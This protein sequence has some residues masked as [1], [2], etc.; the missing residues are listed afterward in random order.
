MRINL[1]LRLI[2]LVFIGSIWT[3][4]NSI[5]ILSID[6]EGNKRLTAEDIMRNAQLFEGMNIDGDDIQ[7]GI[8]RL[9]NLD[10]FGNIQIFITEEEIDG[11][12]L[13]IQVVEFPILD[14]I[15]FSGKKR[16][17]VSTLNDKI[18]LQLGQILSDYDI[19]TAMSDLKSF[20][21]SKHYHNVEIDTIIT[22]GSIDFSQ[23][24][25]FVINAGKKLKIIKPEIK[26]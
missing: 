26:K 22:S 15:I 11:V 25:E 6:V 18:D 24:V 17:S 2:I 21:K 20:Y 8:K 14:Q 23:S 9:W 16:K 3:Q 1:F 12:H 7:K 4:S 10:R 5:K 19:Y 13:L